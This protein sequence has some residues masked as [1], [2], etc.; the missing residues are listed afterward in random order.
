MKRQTQKLMTIQSTG[1]STWGEKG[2]Y[3]NINSG[4]LV[5]VYYDY[6]A[7]ANVLRHRLEG[8]TGRIFGRLH[9]HTTITH[10]DDPATLAITTFFVALAIVAVI[11]SWRNFWRRNDA[12]SG[13]SSSGR[14]PHVSD[15]DY[16]YIT[17]DDIGGPSEYS[18]Y[19]G[20]GGGGG[21]QQHQHQR[22]SRENTTF[23]DKTNEY[24]DS[25]PDILLLKH[26]RYKYTLAFPAYA[27]DDGV[28]R[29]G[30]LRRRAAEVT[31]TADPQRVKLLY[32]GKLLDEDGWPCKAE[33]M[34]QESEVLCVVSEVHP[35]E[36]SDMEMEDGGG[37]GGGDDG[38]AVSSAVGSGVGSG[39]STRTGS[40]RKNKKKN[41]N[42]KR[43][44]SPPQQQQQPSPST[45]PTQTEPL[46]IPQQHRPP[47]GRGISTSASSLPAPAPNLKNFSTPQEQIDALSNYLQTELLP[48][49]DEYTTNTPTEPK[50]R[51]FEHKKISETVLAQ[52]L[53]KADGIEPMGNPD[54]RNAR[55]QLVKDAQ[56][57]LNRVDQASK[58]T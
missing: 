33:G 20:G 10:P 56:S 6:Y 18:D 26:H 13:P 29:V 30:D 39:G 34:K 28:L 25:D 49:C 2:A 21:R 3:N 40:K 12:K 50:L 8:L 22:R 41:N 37:V 42:K 53:L 46:P 55:K 44:T 54:V 27:I 51:D 35:D 31:R 48:L 45:P 24:I 36:T 19:R 43:H 5:Q 58:V 15:N 47:P 17:H 11:M 57:I 52:V 14:P 38:S 1:Q 32:K 4:R 16:S 7:N 9:D 23:D